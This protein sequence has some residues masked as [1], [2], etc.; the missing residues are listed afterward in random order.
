LKGGFAGVDVFFVISGYLITAI[1]LREMASGRYRILAF[2]GRRVRRIFPALITVML[3]VA[4]FGYFALFAEEYQQLGKHMVGGATFASN[5]VLWQEAGYFDQAS[6]T[7]PLLHLWSLGVEEQFYLLWPLLLWAARRT[8]RFFFHVLAGVTLLSFAAN[9]AWLAYDRTFLFYSPLTRF[10]EL[11]AGGLLVYLQQHATHLPRA[12]LQLSARRNLLAWLGLVLITVAY[13]I[14]RERMA[15]PSGWAVL[16]VLGALLLIAAGPQAMVNRW[17]LS[18]PVMVFIGLISFPLYLWHWPLLSF[19]RIYYSAMPP[20]YVRAACVLASLL[21]AVATYWLVERPLRF[22]ARPG[23]IITLLCL[24]MLGVGVLGA[25]IWQQKG[26]PWRAAIAPYANNTQQ[27]VRTPSRD[28]ACSAYIGAQ[29]SFYYCR[30]H[31]AKADRTVALIGDSHAHVTFPGVATL[32]EARGYNVVL[33]ANTGCPPLL[34]TA[35]GE[36][37]ADRARCAAQTKQLVAIAAAKPDITDVFIR[38]RGAFYISGDGFGEAEKSHRGKPI[39]SADPASDDIPPADLFAHGLERT[40]RTLQR[41]GKRVHYILENPEMG[42]DVSQ[43]IARPLRT[44]AAACDVPR[45]TVEARQYQYRQLVRAIAQLDVIDP[46][47]AFCPQQQCQAVQD[48]QLL[49]ADD[50]HLS[51]AGSHFMAQRVLA[52]Y[53]PMKQNVLR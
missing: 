10:W 12:W 19:A 43:C 5:L 45:T 39:R 44:E 37:A 7:K 48:K 8:P 33:L 30:Y 13:V 42:I 52:P 40:V 16:P 23:R 50:N 17:F 47:P 26:L 21:L 34:G 25:V 2:Y 14:L 18:H 6:D 27:L 15:Y 41:A 11:S 36:T 38:T 46:L 32:M 49:Y 35:T 29:P 53:M 24:A 9:L 51:V 22:G 1:L 4:A 28:D 31:D 3:A 20:E